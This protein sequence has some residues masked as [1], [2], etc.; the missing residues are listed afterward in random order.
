[1]FL[2]TSEHDGTTVWDELMW[3]TLSHRPFVEDNF[4]NVTLRRGTLKNDRSF[5]TLETNVIVTS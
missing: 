5:L 4:K 1:M 2:K 3:M